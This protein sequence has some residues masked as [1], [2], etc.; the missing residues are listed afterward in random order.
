MDSLIFLSPFVNKFLSFFQFIFVNQTKP[1]RHSLLLLLLGIV[2]TSS[3]SVRK[4]YMRI[5]SRISGKSLNSF[6]NLLT[7]GKIDLNVWSAQLIRLSLRCIPAEYEDA[8]ILLAVDDTLVEKEGSHFAHRERL[9]DHSG[10]RDKK[11]DNEN[12]QERKGYFINGH[13]FVS[14]VMLIPAMMSS[15]LKYI[16]IV[17]AQRMWNKDLNKLDI[18]Y[19]LVLQ[20]RSVIGENRQLIL[21]CDSWYPKGKIAGLKNLQNIDIICNVRHDSVMIELTPPKKEKGAVGRHRTKGDRV[22]LDDF[23]LVPVPETIYFVGVRMVKAKIFGYKTVTAIVTRQGEQGSRRLFF[24]TNDAICSFFQQHIES[25]AGK[26]A[27][28]Y[29]RTDIR[30]IPLAIYSLRWNIEMSYLELKS[31][32]DFREYRVRSQ[33]SIERLLNLLSL[34]YSVCSLLPALD[35]DFVALE[36]QSIQERRWYM[37]QQI[38]QEIVFKRLESRLPNDENKRAILQLCREIALQDDLA[39]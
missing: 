15:G 17:V 10:Y 5:I 37:E 29:A 26:E 9:F 30:F 19:E 23:E 14:L 27:K 36:R 22:R 3:L 8:P 35:K 33:E 16:P 24:C 6:Y 28:A 38:S 25:I 32:W 39:A 18:A 34:A 7:N 20:A 12:S 13:C 1:T 31:F 4:C 21:L 11:N 2:M